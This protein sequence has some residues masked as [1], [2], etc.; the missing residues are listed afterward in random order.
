MKKLLTVLAWALLTYSAQAQKIECVGSESPL[1]L[2]TA[3]G[4][5]TT[6][7]YKVTAAS[8]MS[9]DTVLIA[10]EDG[11]ASH[12]TNICMPP[13]WTFDIAPALPETPMLHP[14]DHRPKTSHGTVTAASGLCPFMIR[15]L[16]QGGGVPIP[17]SGQY[18]FGFDNPGSPH[19]VEWRLS[20]GPHTNWSQSV[21]GGLGPVHAPDTTCIQDT[22]WLNSGMGIT[23]PGLDPN[24]SVIYD[25]NHPAGHPNAQV[26]QSADW[27][28]PEPNSQ[29]ISGDATDNQWLGGYGYAEFE[30]C[31]CLKAPLVNP[32]LFIGVRADNIVDVYLNGALIL[33]DH[34]SDAW[35]AP[36]TYATVTTPSSFFVGRNCVRVKVFNY[37]TS[38]GGLTP[39]GADI[40]GWVTQDNRPGTGAGVCCDTCVTCFADGDID[41]DGIP[42]AVADLVALSKF[43]LGVGPAPIPLCRADMNADGYIDEGDAEIFSCYFINGMTCF[44]VFPVPPICN[45]DTLRGASCELDGCHI[46]SQHNCELRNGAYFGDGT[47]C[48]PEF[49]W[50]QICGTKFNDLN[51][52]GDQDA[53]EPPVSGVQ[54]TFVPAVSGVTNP[55]TTDASG[56]WC[57]GPMPAGTYKFYETVPANMAQT[58]PASIYLTADVQP[59]LGV[60]LG[61]VFG[62]EDTCLS[63]N[64]HLDICLAGKMDNFATADGVEL[65][66]PSTALCTILQSCSAGPRSNC[67]PSV[68]NNC[69]EFDCGGIDRCFG[70]TFIGC[71]DPSC[72]VIHARLRMRIR[73]AASGSSNDGFGLSQNGVGVWSTFISDLN[74]GHWNAGEV[75]DVTLDLEHLPAS[76]FYPG[77]TNVLAALQDG[78]LDVL[79]QDDTE[80]DF[81]ELRVTTCCHCVTPPSDMVA[82][83]PGDELTGSVAHDIAGTVVDNGTPQP[84][85]IGSAGGP[86][87]V[88][89]VVL[90]GL[91]FPAGTSPT[92]GPNVYVE[93]PTS[94]EV[95]FGTGDFTIDAWIKMGP[96]SGSIFPIVDKLDFSVPGSNR[97]YALFVQGGQLLIRLGPDDFGGLVAAVSVFASP[98]V[99]GTWY[100][101]GVA[102]KRG[103]SKPQVTF[104][105]DGAPNGPIP[106]AGPNMSAPNS[107]TGTTPLWI[108]GHSRLASG[109]ATVTRGEIVIDELEY[110]HRELTALEI[111]TIWGAGGFGKCKPCC[112]CPNQGDINGDGVV[113]VFDVIELIN[114]AFAGT[115]D[116]QDPCCPLTR[117]DVNGD[118]IV[119]VFDVIYLIDTAFGGGATPVNPCP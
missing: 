68:P 99:V 22:I 94:S 70:H 107:I 72:T 27:G 52:D 50:G 19:D 17:P 75:L 41:G 42:L 12:Y 66:A 92:P 96:A 60:D 101:V 31:F 87:S 115:A 5:T 118:G 69:S 6:Y 65:A 77:I 39:T 1:P 21:G 49:C 4:T 43:I 53:G 33:T 80:V 45:P 63:V 18:I 11:T 86:S 56:M 111:Q 117:G 61:P 88:P 108:G 44:P 110:F 36:P 2:P 28:P 23:P 34:S 48:S 58:A 16:R 13:G 104:Y 24:W 93:V 35:L 98:M 57:F 7:A 71:W 97:G 84:A 76:T 109:G 81:L 10:T 37:R 25:Q 116:P 78:D 119:D 102:V 89:A 15:F 91:S 46:R 64:Q 95:N 40:V 8:M 105:V 74:S 90:N 51:G 54:I 55:V 83:W 114:I 112:N 20:N 106:T 3:C 26:L 32:K 103:A 59:Q 14:A 38:S 30:F 9:V 47:T 67:N 113:D 29:W 100:H 85:P 82:W 73:A 62:N 79:I